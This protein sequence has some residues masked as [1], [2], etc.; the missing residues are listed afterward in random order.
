MLSHTNKKTKQNKG[1][2]IHDF[3]TQVDL[4]YSLSYASNFMKGGASTFHISDKQ[5]M[6]IQI[7]LLLLSDW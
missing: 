4:S 7:S 6:R 5:L 3:L 1:K 2:R